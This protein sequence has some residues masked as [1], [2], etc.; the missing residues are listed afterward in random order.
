MAGAVYLSSDIVHFGNR[1]LQFGRGVRQKHL[2]HPLSTVFPHGVQR[3]REQAD[4]KF[5][6]ESLQIYTGMLKL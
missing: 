5:S 2:P 6:G 4:P 1:R 3:F